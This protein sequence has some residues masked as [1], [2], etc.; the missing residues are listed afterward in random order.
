M[1]AQYH[2]AK[3]LICFVFSSRNYNVV[4]NGDISKYF[5]YSCQPFDNVLNDSANTIEL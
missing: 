3:G 5:R 2:S 4:L 1:Y